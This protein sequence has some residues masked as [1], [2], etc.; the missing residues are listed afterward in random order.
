MRKITIF[1]FA[2]LLFALPVQAG[3]SQSGGKMTFEPEQIVR[4]A[5][6]VET[7]LAESGARVALVARVGRPREKLPEGIRFTHVAFAVY[8]KIQLDNGKTVPGYAV[9]NLYQRDDQKNVSDLI[10]DYPID[11]FAGSQELEA[12][13]VLL[14]PKLQKRLLQ[15]ITSEAYSSMHNP[16]YSCISNPFTT[17]Y[18]NCTEFV[19]D[20]LFGAIYQVDDKKQIKLN[21][22]AYFRAQPVNKNPLLLLGGSIFSS[23]VAISDHPNGKIETATFSTIANFLIQQKAAIE[24]LTITL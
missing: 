22:R 1:F 16:R 8:S 12:G 11:F 3:S 10:Q 14:S 2:V 6:K 9:Y 5:K 15:V 13:I 23:E 4:L 7:T 20:V 19:L 18:Q 21:E 17:A 24:V